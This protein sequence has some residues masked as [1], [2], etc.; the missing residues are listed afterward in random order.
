MKAV[1]FGA[2]GQDGFYL[3]H[4]CNQ[5]EIECIAVSRSSCSYKG[6]VSNYREVEQLIHRYN[7]N[8]IFHLAAN[9]TTLHSAL[10]ENHQTIATGTLN[11]LEAVYK[12]SPTTKVFITGSGLQF[13][14]EGLPIVEDSPFDATSPYTIARIQSVYAARYYR[15]LGLKVYVGYLFHHESPLRKPNHISQ[16]IIQAV[17]NIN[18]G[19]QNSLE[20]GDVSIEKEWTFAGDVAK[21]IFTLVQQDNLYEAVIGSGITYSI[22][23]WLEECFK[24]I[25]KNWQNYVFLKEGFRSEY[26]RLVSNP[27]KIKSLHWQPK[28]SLKELAQIMYNSQTIPNNY[29]F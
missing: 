27:Q 11:I 24:L 20:L 21:A 12:H 25:G 10:F 14:N 8:Y 2:N 28:I 13:K 16:M 3:S 23:D 9:S 4:L 18:L 15:S 1:I 7:P 6:D 29:N 17:K 22:Q 26:K 5:Q 19:K